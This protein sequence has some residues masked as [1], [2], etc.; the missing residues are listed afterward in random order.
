MSL[1]SVNEYG[2][3]RQ[4]F[5]ANV[6][7]AKHVHANDNR[8]KTVELELDPASYK[9]QNNDV[10]ALLIKDSK[11]P[12]FI[13]AGSI[14][15]SWHFTATANIPDASA[16]VCGYTNDATANNK[17]AINALAT[18]VIARDHPVTG[19]FFNTFKQF[20]IDDRLD[21]TAATN[22]LAVLDM[23]GGDALHAMDQR[24]NAGEPIALVPSIAIT[25]GTIPEGALRIAITYVQQ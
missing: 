15:E 10:H 5:V 13:P 20:S 6:I 22:L 16:I 25:A 24:F 23:D 3:R 14:I 18:R 7:D 21:A 4:D 17:D 11:A 9:A 8:R 12:L 1:P 2:F 19:K